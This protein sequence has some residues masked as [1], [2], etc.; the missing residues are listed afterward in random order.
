MQT[1]ILRS[2][3]LVAVGNAAL[4]GK[5]VSRF[6]P[7]AAMLQYY[8]K[9]EFMLPA[10]GGQAT[11]YAAD[12]LDWFAKL[13][14]L[15]CRGLRLH[16]APMQQRPGAAPQSER[17]M[18]GLLGGGPRWLIEVLLPTRCELWEGFDRLGDRRAPDRKIWNV[19]YL[20]IGE[21]NP[22]DDAD[23]N[24]A[25]A[26]EEVRG[27]LIEIEAFAR[28]LPGAPF[29]DAFAGA[30]GVLDGGASVYT[31]LDV[32]DLTAL[33][34][35]ARRL[36]VGAAQGWVFGAMGSWN[37]VV[38]DPSRVARYADTSEALFVALQRAVTVAANST[39]A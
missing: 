9:F 20:R 34:P 24:V 21:T 17:M 30:R 38:V 37:D 11:P 14:A 29:A 12:P 15:G 36:L 18:V 23:R 31:G 10:E 7:E 13:K 5:D 1:N 32:L 22:Q 26:T 25:A 16:T 2:F 35:A 39:C 27:A 8:R 33:G 28:D 19:A 3:A 4:A 6:W